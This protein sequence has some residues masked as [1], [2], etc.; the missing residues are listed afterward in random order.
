[1]KFIFTFPTKTKEII[2]TDFK[3]AFSKLTL[4]QRT[5]F[6]SVY[7]YDTGEELSDSDIFAMYGYDITLIDLTDEQ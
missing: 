4:S 5:Y 3:D 7:C 6:T 2:A 1:M